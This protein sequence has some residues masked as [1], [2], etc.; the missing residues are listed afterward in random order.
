MKR[1][2]QDLKGYVINHEICEKPEIRVAYMQGEKFSTAGFT[3]H[4]KLAL[5]NHKQHVSVSTENSA[6]VCHNQFAL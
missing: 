3:D 5:P 4:S 6:S 2:G 1:S